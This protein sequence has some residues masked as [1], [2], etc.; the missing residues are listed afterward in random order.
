YDGQFNPPAPVARVSLRVHANGK[1][2][3]DVPMLIDSGADVTLLPRARVDDH[4]GATRVARVIPL[5]GARR[6]PLGIGPGRDQF[7]SILWPSPSANCF[8][9][10]MA[11]PRSHDLDQGCRCIPCH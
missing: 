9:K 5:P 4:L 11:R 2:V 7:E 10:N 1:I 8:E 3:T 6:R